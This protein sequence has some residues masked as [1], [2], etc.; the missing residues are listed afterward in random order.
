[1]TKAS[2]R[3]VQNVKHPYG[4]AGHISIDSLLSEEKMGSGIRIFAK[5]EVKQFCEIGHHEHH[6][7]TEAYYILSGKGLYDDNGKAIPVE[8]GDVVF[9]EDGHGHGIK[10]DHPEDLVFIALVIKK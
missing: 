1:M 10:N 9:C 6:N 8:A 2:E 3:E 4:G 7:E 5:V